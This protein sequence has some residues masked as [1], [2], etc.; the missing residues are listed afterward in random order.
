MVY[1]NEQ[2]IVNAL[3]SRSLGC[4]MVKVRLRP[5]DRLKKLPND[6]LAF[7]SVESSVVTQLNM[8]GVVLDQY[9]FDRMILHDVAVTHDRLR[10]LC[11]GTLT[12]SHEGLQPSKSRAEKQIIGTR[13]VTLSLTYI[14]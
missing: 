1:A 9:H 8:N 2:L 12:S 4:L 11:V 10:M 6:S 3:Y 14:P 13:P 7:L 5:Y